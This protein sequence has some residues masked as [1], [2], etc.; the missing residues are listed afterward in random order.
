ML[1]GVFL[2]SCGALNQLMSS[3]SHVDC[4]RQSSPACHLIQNC[5]KLCS[6]T[7]V[8]HTKKKEESFCLTLRK[9][10]NNFQTLY[11]SNNEKLLFRQSQ[12]KKK[13]NINYILSQC[14]KM[15]SLISFLYDLKST[16][17]A[18]LKIRSHKRNTLMMKKVF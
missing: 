2:L 6:S 8:T 14:T 9:A 3:L 5:F 10:R 12:R 17:Y 18:K 16:T 15:D 4:H 7:M 1:S 11:K 13:T